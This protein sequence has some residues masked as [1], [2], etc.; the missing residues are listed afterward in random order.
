MLITECTTA[1]E[2]KRILIIDDEQL[3]LRALSRVLTGRGYSVD[4]ANNGR[5]ALDLMDV[6]TYHGIICDVHMPGLEG[7]EV[8]DLALAK[9]GESRMPGWVFQSGVPRDPS[10]LRQRVPFLTKPVSVDDLLDT[11]RGVLK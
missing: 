5:E 11:L 4:T 6:N 1:E 3:I 10:E 8:Y 7:F 2:K 9:L